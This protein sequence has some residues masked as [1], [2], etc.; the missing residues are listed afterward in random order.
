MTDDALPRCSACGQVLASEAGWS[1]ADLSFFDFRTRN[2]RNVSIEDVEWIVAD[3]KCVTFHV[4][5][6][7]THTETVRTITGLAARWPHLLRVSR[8]TLVNPSAVLQ[9]EGRQ[10]DGWIRLRNGKRLS[11]AKR[12]WVTVR[13]QFAAWQQCGPVLLRSPDAPTPASSQ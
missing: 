8:G 7:S 1:R 2:R 5:D 13:N 10:D 3:R 11:V 4:A 12:K 9:L 6:G